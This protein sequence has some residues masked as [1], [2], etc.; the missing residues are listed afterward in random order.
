[1]GKNYLVWLSEKQIIQQFAIF[2]DKANQFH[3]NSA[4]VVHLDFKSPLA[5]NLPLC[6][7][8][9]TH[10]EQSWECLINPSSLPES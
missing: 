3:S 4:K 9:E 5:D 2:S 10:L 1:M 6:Q 7:N 8:T